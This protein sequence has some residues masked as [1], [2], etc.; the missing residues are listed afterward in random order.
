M[1]TGVVVRLGKEGRGCIVTFPYEIAMTL[2]RK[3]VVGSFL[4]SPVESM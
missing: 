1:N 3:H 2:P 4:A